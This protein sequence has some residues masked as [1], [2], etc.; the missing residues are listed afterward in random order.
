MD[1]NRSHHLGNAAFIFSAMCLGVLWLEV[2]LGIIHFPLVQLIVFGC[3][4]FAAA[5]G[6]WLREA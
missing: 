1:I 3:G 4:A 6:V 2:I 5:L